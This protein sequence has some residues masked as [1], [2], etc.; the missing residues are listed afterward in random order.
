MGFVRPSTPLIA[1]FAAG[2][3]QVGAIC[4]VNDISGQLGK[5]TEAHQQHVPWQSLP[6]IHEVAA[7]HKTGDVWFIG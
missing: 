2:A 5:L 6:A 1:S 7:C 4:N 3:R